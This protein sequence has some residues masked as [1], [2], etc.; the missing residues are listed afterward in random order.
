MNIFK[1]IIIC[2][3]LISSLQVYSL[4]ENI[5]T[6]D[7]PCPP[8]LPA[9]FRWSGRY[10]VPNL[11]DIETGKWVDVSFTWEANNGNIQMIAGSESEAIYFTN[12][13]NNGYL[14][15]YTYKWPNL[16]PE[17]LPP[18]ERCD[19]VRALTLEELNFFFTT[20]YFVG[21]EII[22]SPDGQKQYVNHF[23][24]SIVQP[25]L[26]PGFYPRLPIALGD[27]YV[28]RK[29]PY[30]IYKILHFGLE[31]LYAPGLDEWIILDKFEDCPREII[32]PAACIISH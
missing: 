8:Q 14:Y 5:E 10:I 19:P 20:A 11:T 2:L 18:L 12:F 1:I 4:E 6:I 3:S 24:I 27:I 23:R 7:A 32:I 26:P 25:M 21:P 16:Q 15:T 29:D 31:N 28:D 9:N 17:F 30:K 22:K 13:I